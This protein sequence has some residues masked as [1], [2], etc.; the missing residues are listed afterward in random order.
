MSETYL[1]AFILAVVGGFLDA[2][3]YVIRGGVFANAQTGNVVLLGI[4]VVE[5]EWY[6]CLKYIIQIFMFVV[7]VTMSDIAKKKLSKSRFHWRQYIIAIEILVVIG[8]GFIPIGKFNVVAN[9]MI[10]FVSSLQIQSFRKIDSVGYSTTICTGNLRTATEKIYRYRITGDKF[11]LKSGI[12]VYQIVGF[13]LLG[14][15]VG[16]NATKFLGQYSVFITAFLLLTVLML[17]FI[18]KEKEKNIQDEFFD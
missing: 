15:I 5:G 9:I 2:Y 17:M 8:V 4:S 18:D 1:V 10:T 6:R 14:V 3:S 11:Y 12:R 16:A 7:G 13:F